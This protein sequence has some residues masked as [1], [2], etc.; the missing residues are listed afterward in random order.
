MARDNFKE[1]G[2]DGIITVVE[3]D[4]HEKIKELKGPLDMVFIDAEKE[5]YM[6]YLKQLMPLVRPG[7]LILAHNTTNSRRPLKGFIDTIT[8]DPGLVT[9]FCNGSDRGMSVSMKKAAGK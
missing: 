9:V 6:D 3:G 8:S 1:A 7:G 4:A 2:V 5:G